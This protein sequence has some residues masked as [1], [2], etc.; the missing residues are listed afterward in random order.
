[1]AAKKPAKHA[2]PDLTD[3][4][5]VR[6]NGEQLKRHFEAENVSRKFLERIAALRFG[7]TRGALSTLRSRDAL[8]EKLY[9]L[10]EHESTHEAISRA[11]LGKQGNNSTES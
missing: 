7:M 9:K 5:V 4:Q 1:M 8:T 3:D 10:L 2:D 6:L 11:A